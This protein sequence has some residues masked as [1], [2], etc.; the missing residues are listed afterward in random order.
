[1]WA[2]WRAEGDVRLG[3]LGDG[4]KRRRCWLRGGLLQRLDDESG[5]GM[6][7]WLLLWRCRRSNLRCRWGGAHPAMC[8]GN[9]E[10]KPEGVGDDRYWTRRT[11]STTSASIKLSFARQAVGVQTYQ[12]AGFQVQ[13]VREH[14]HQ[15]VNRSMQQRP[16]RPPVS[17]PLPPRFGPSSRI[18][19]AS[20]LEGT[21]PRTE[22]SGRPLGPLLDVIRWVD[23]EATAPLALALEPLTTS[24]PA[25]IPPAQ[26]QA[27]AH[28]HPYVPT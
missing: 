15:A 5:M 27:Q 21:E 13:S 10:E 22:P 16:R 26:P 25:P 24:R 23:T 11:T 12:D 8:R 4:S 2:I 28:A 7:R 20:A 18:V 14:M 3:S 1:M 17:E 9:K 6:L 19:S